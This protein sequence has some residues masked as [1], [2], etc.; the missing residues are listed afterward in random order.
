MRNIFWALS[1]MVN[2]AF[3][4]IGTVLLVI[5]VLTGIYFITAANT[6]TFLWAVVFWLCVG[7]ALFILSLWINSKP[8]KSEVEKQADRWFEEQRRLD[9]IRFQQWEKEFH[10]RKKEQDEQNKS[11]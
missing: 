10:Q 1:E 7:I 11:I 2:F 6:P 8:A 4:L 9:Q 3:S 5:L